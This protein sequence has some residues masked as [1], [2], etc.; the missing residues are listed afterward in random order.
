MTA[1]VITAE[2]VYQEAMIEHETVGAEELGVV[3][4]R[5]MNPDQ[6]RD[7]G[8]FYTPQALA[9][10]LARFSLDIGLDEVG[11]DAAQVLRI[12][13]LDPSCGSGIML[14]HAARLLSHAYATRLL[15]GR[16]PSGD[17]ML[18]VMPRV[19]LECV[20]GVD[21][22]PVAAE[23]ARLALSLETAGALAPA[24][25]ERHVVCDNVLDGP[26]H[27]PPALADRQRLAQINKE[28]DR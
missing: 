17:L 3:Y 5:L 15:G 11:P 16:E 26:D 12:T 23:L 25:L 24:M 18:A 13:A 27:L 14:V 28:T 7:Q 22:D 2:D 20:Y 4:Q 19:I 9:E 21:I 8:S 1:P 6:R 10:F